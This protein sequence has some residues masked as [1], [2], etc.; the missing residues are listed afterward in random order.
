MGRT[1]EIGNKLDLLFVVNF[2]IPKASKMLNK[3]RSYASCSASLTWGREREREGALA[4]GVGMSGRSRVQTTL[5]RDSPAEKKGASVLDNAAAEVSAEL[6]QKNAS[7][8][9][10]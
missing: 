6:L 2:K 4:E 7:P 8:Q 3:T 1:S 5:S 10:T 9:K